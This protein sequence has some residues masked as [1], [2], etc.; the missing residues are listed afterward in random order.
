MF[1]IKNFRSIVPLK[2]LRIS[3]EKC[4]RVFLDYLLLS[5]MRSV[6]RWC[7]KYIV[8]ETKNVVNYIT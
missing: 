5:L 6:Q 3:A 2:K 1:M 8:S 4:M 7:F